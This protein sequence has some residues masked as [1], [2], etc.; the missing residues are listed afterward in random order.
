MSRKVKLDFI[1]SKYQQD[2]FDW[3]EHGVGNAVIEAS[4]GSGK[5]FLAVNAMKFIPKT[6][7]C[8]FIA[9]NKAIANELNLR[10]KGRS[11]ITARTTHS[12]GYLMVRRNLG[13]HIE[14]DE[15][16][17][18]SYVKNNIGELTTVGERLTGN[19]KLLEY[20]DNICALIDFSR[21]NLAQSEKEI[22][23]IARKYDIA[24]SLD[25]CLVVK[26]C[27][28]WGRES[29]DTIDYTDMLWLPNELSLKP[30]GMTYDWVF[31]DEAQDASLASEKLFLKCIKRGGRFVALGDRNQMINLFAGSSEDAFDYLC[32]YS[33]TT[34][35]PLPVTF[36]CAKNIVKIAN[37]LVPKIMAK[38]DAPEGIVVEECHIRDFKDGDM[39]L[40]R[41]CAPL[42][43]LY[44]KLLKRGV[45][46]FIK[47]ADIGTNLINILE[48]IDKEELGA[49]LDKDGVFVRLYDKLFNERN[50]LMVTRNMDFDDA[51]LSAQIMQKY[52]EINALMVLGE[53]Y[54]TKKSLIK[55]IQD[56]FK[57]EDNGVCLSTIHKAK[58][59][60]ADNVYIL[61]RSMMPSK[62]AKHEWE[63]RQEFN[64][65]YVAYTRAK[66]KL[67]FVS[68]KEVPPV[69]ATQK[70]NMIIN[71]L[72]YI[73]KCV[74]SILGKKPMERL[75]NVEIARFKLQHKTRIIDNH[76][77]DNKIEIDSATTGNTGN[78]SKTDQDLLSQLEGLI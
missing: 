47:G 56:I 71:E 20:V 59:L 76:E 26:K 46:C 32:N 77:E 48:G 43:R 72:C 51:T 27:L 34:I 8:L 57:E 40:A 30:V 24:V 67:G 14:V 38:D 41:T 22:N 62:L 12:L 18:R 23:D 13:S 10:L 64:L 17:Y 55:H 44:T 63:K 78:V 69:G 73:E 3:V 11:N 29:Y 1:P 58:G 45:N 16:K 28:E 2:F 65:I 36:R 9:F 7:K 60:E 37:T 70:P 5:T 68:E 39:V 4:A 33:N 21:L 61:C 53:K 66:N 19:Q 74:C 75:E 52:D 31:L 49:N 35:F 25:E 42:V 15:Y 54:K 50:K 6:E